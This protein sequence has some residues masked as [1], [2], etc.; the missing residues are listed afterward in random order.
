MSKLISRKRFHKTNSPAV[1]VLLGSAVFL[2]LAAASAQA[3][4]NPP[5]PS[6]N[7]R[8]SF[9]GQVFVARPI[10]ESEEGQLFSIDV[11][12]TIVELTELGV[13]GQTQISDRLIIEPYSI[14]FQSDPPGSVGGPG[15]TIPGVQ[16]VSENFNPISLRFGSDVENPNGGGQLSDFVDV[17]IAGTLVAHF[18]LFDS[19]TV[20]E[21]PVTFAGGPYLFDMMEPGRIPSLSDT[22]DI[23]Q[24]LFSFVSDS[25]EEGLPPI[26]V[27]PNDAFFSRPELGEA[28]SYDVVA[29]SDIDVPEPSSLVLAALGLIGLAA[30]SCRRKR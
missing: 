9:N 26:S 15:R 2:W 24:F 14:Q 20:P 4:V 27:L 6:D 7:V 17:L 28:F 3:Q 30:R 19:P 21:T 16:Q 1:L 5:G 29:F 11:P 18:D 22:L 8:V 10:S 12:R 25:T 13:T 23:Q